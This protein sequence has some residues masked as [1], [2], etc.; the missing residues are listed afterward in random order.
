MNYKI[1][2]LIGIF[3]LSIAG[4]SQCQQPILLNNWTDQNGTWIVNPGNT[5]VKQTPNVI[6]DAYF[7]SPNNYINVLISGNFKTTDPDHDDDIMGF[8]FGVEGTIGSGSFHCYRLQWDQGGMGNG[9]YINEISQNGSTTLYANP[10]Y[11]WTL[12]FNHAFTIIYKSTYFEVYIDGNFK[13]KILGCFNPGKFGFYDRSQPH[14]TYSNFSYKALADFVVNDN[15]CLGENTNLRIF[16]NNNTFH[17][18]TSIKWDLGDGNIVYNSINFTHIYQQPGTYYIT[19][20]VHDIFGCVDSVTKQT[21]VHPSPS[22]NFSSDTVCLNATNTFTDFSTISSGTISGWQWDLNADGTIDN[23]TQNPTYTYSTCGIFDARLITMSD[24]GCK[25]TVN[26]PALVNCLPAANFV[27]NP[28]CKDQPAI[29]ND[30][31]LGNI[32]N[33]NW[34]FGD[35]D[36]SMTQNPIHTYAT[37]GTFNS[38][39]IVTDSVGCKDSITKTVTINCLPSADF[40]FTNVCLNQPMNLYDSST[41]LNGTI[42]GWLWDFGGGTPLGTTQHTSPVYANY[43]TYN[44]SLIVATTSSCKDTITKNVV[45]HPLPNAEFST[46]NVCHGSNV[47][48]NDLSDI[49]TTDSLQYW[50][51]NFDDGSPVSANQSTFHLYST[52]GSYDVTLLTVSYFGCKDSAIKTSIVHPIPVVNFTAT[53]SIGCEP[54][55]ISFQNLSHIATG[56][57]VGCLWDLGDGSVT[58]NLED[59]DHCYINDSVFS[60]VSFTPVLTVTSDSGCV[61]SLSKNNYITTYPLPNANFTAQP[62]TTTVIDP[63]ISITDLSEGTDFWNWDFGDQDTSLQ[64]NPS[65]HTYADT[66]IYQIMLIASTQYTCVDTAYQTISIGWD[67]AFYIPNAFTPDGDGL[68]DTFTGKGIF[69][70]QYSMSIFDRWGNLIF[71]TDDI[72]TPWDGKANHGSEIAQRDVYVYSIK[73]TDFKK[74]K[75]NY[76]GAVTLLR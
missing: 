72:N 52:P 46:A 5:S 33:W 41:V 38:K 58:S 36:T 37:C 69:I 45:V 23:T 7:L 13:T 49:P 62:E 25:D 63:V 67:F 68:N 43:G 74:R 59:L 34:E 76:N 16:C 11:H 29:F 12:N 55:C 8:V 54:L 6:G 71:L 28:V 53:D 75:H 35:T 39:L 56:T 42:A 10:G 64:Y 65:P 9:M 17:N 66:G 26:L 21:T 4:Y 51:W 2:L 22:A 40:S 24:N 31:T 50:L 27:T 14:V 57:N 44:V 47:P 19:E 70:S 73:V 61:S 60:P 15:V 18:Y 20:T 3:Y 32:L 48:F 30:S 1:L